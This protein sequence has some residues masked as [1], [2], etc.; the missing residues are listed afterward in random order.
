MKKYLFF[1]IFIFILNGIAFADEIVIKNDNDTPVG[2]LYMQGRDC[3]EE[4]VV[5]TPTG[6][7]NIKKI[8]VYYSSPSNVPLKDTL[9]ICGFPTSGNL[10][11]TQYIWPY[12]SLIKPL[13]VEFS[14]EPGW[15]E[16][17][18]SQ[19]GL[20]SD[21]YDKIVIQHRMKSQGPWFTY[22][23]GPAKA[24]PSS[25]ITDPFTPNPNFYNIAGTIYQ[26]PPGNFMVRMSVEYD[27]P[28][29]DIS[30][31][32][33]PPTMV[34]VT[35]QAGLSGG[36]YVS[37]VDLNK[38]GWDDIVMGSNVFENQ[39]DGTFKNIND[40]TSISASGTAW[41]DFDNDGDMDC[42]ALLNGAQDF[43]LHCVF[44]KDAVYLNQGDGTM[45][46]A[47]SRDVFELP[48]PSPSADFNL[49]NA[50]NQDS[51]HNPYNLITPV[52]FDYNGDGYP[53]LFLANRRMEDGTHS[54]IYCP[55][56]LWKNT[57]NGKFE[58]VT[59]PSGI[60]TG[61]PYI[62]PS[63][64]GY[65]YLDCYGAAAND[66]NDD[67]L[68]DMFVANYRL[69]KDNLFKNN[70]DGT[71]AEVGAQTG[72]R[73]IPT[74]AAGYFGHGMGCQWG[75]FNNDGYQDLAVGNLAHTDSRAIYSNPSLI[76]SNDGPPNFT[77]T[78]RQPEMVL[79]YHEGNAGM[80][81]LDL[82]LD[83]LLDLWHGKYSGGM[84]SLYLNTGAPTYKLREITWETG[85]VVQDPW[86]A[87]R[88]DFD[89]DG[90]MDLMIGNKLFRNDMPRRGKW[91]TFRLKGNPAEKVCYDAFG[92]KVTVYAAG[93]IFTRDL[94]GSSA[95]SLCTQNTF[96][97]HFGLGEIEKADS[98]IVRYPN[99][100]INKITEIELNAKYRIPYMQQPVLSMLATPAL[101]SPR[102]FYV[103]DS[104]NQVIA[105]EG[106]PVSGAIGYK[107]S[108]YKDVEGEK[109]FVL[110]MND[111]TPISPKWVMNDCDKYYW[112]IEA[113]TKN[114]SR[115]SDYWEFYSCP[116]LPSKPILTSPSDNSENIKAKPIFEWEK[117]VYDYK[118]G[119]NNKYQLQVDKNSDFDSPEIQNFSNIRTELFEP[120][121]FLTS[122]TTYFWRVCGLNGEKPGP[123]SDVFSFTVRALP[124]KP[125]LRLPANEAI[126]IAAM[127]NLEWESQSAAT[128]YEVQV[129]LTPDFENIK[130][131]RAN[132]SGT[133][134]KVIPKLDGGTVYYWKVRAGN[135]GGKSDWSD[136]W[137]FKTGG[138]SDV[139]YDYSPE[140]NEVIEITPNPASEQC[141]IKL[142]IQNSI[143]SQ[144]SIFNSLG[145]EVFVTNLGK[146]S[147]NGDNFILNTRYFASGVYYCRLKTEKNV[148]SK[149]FIIIK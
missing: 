59:N 139:I 140:S 148:F 118:Y 106:Y 26:Y 32:P 143:A 149:Q 85:C 34:D 84:G 56:K 125:Q 79:K 114:L 47:A 55:D 12:N 11:P 92:T 90:D 77:F 86:T 111:T 40:K 31:Q 80:C 10:W 57:G 66:Y 2:S 43:N 101:K 49:P 1:L 14:G 137:N 105:F 95:G 91:L 28:D 75:D 103:A 124:S 62:Y 122:G 78:N 130:F 94:M 123:W 112:R 93:K 45:L 7:C 136:V 69:G 13:Y 73:G 107:I 53:D 19:S 63:G 132:V 27:F 71:F 113:N 24:M 115:T 119:Y 141:W 38:D 5:L 82:D 98:I 102:N 72:V 88:L 129:S 39:K 44:S 48:Y 81:W 8:M 68:V 131:Q 16:I 144:V 17:D 126:D 83:G 29:I 9:M 21:G 37:V 65:G 4:S 128:S 51:I 3:W 61:E 41:A 146:N 121:E 110:T 87:V 109:V 96:E 76:F 20:R 52:F 18:V 23:T 138:E 70:G 134:V 135:E 46:K 33:P 100:K 120:L 42:Y 127:P 30:L 97:L 89:N 99:G 104:L 6:P 58:N 25:W 108:I 54:E 145:I 74:A 50:N 36:G 64:G 67:G 22:D 117:V 116:L 15:V 60:I 142:N 133:A 147:I 35:T